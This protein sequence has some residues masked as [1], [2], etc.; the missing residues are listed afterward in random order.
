MSISS[1]IA[2]ILIFAGAVV[3]AYS[4]RRFAELPK[5]L[6]HSALLSE[7]PRLKRFLSLHQWLMIFFLYG[8]LV[9][10][11]SI[12][13][14]IHIVNELFVSTIFF[15]GALFVLFGIMLEKRM[16][17]SLEQRYSEAVTAN[18]SLQLKQE[19]LISLNRQLVSEMK[20][21]KQAEE[22][23]RKIQDELHQSQKMQA[24]GTLAGG[25]AHD[26]NNILTGIIGFADLIKMKLAGS[27]S[28]MEKYV[29]TIIDSSYQASGLTSKL[30]AFA[31]KGR[32]EM[33][34]VN[35]HGIIGDVIKLLK[36]SIDKR[37]RITADLSAEPPTVLGDPTQLQNTVLNLAVNASEAM[38]QG[39]ELNIT[40]KKV[41]MDAEKVKQYNYKIE[42]GN[43]LLLSVSDTGTGMD[44]ITKKR[45][46]EPFFTTKG[47]GEG[48]GLG[49]ASVY[50][51]VKDHHGSIE[52]ES[53]PGKGSIFTICLPLMEQPVISTP[54]HP[55]ELTKGTGRILI[56]D[57]E[58]IIRNMLTRI[59][60]SLGYTVDECK[61]GQEAVEYYSKN[62]RNIDII[63]L[64][65]MMPRLGGYDCFLQLKEINPDV[66]AIVA[67][68]YSAGKDARKIIEKGALCFIEKPFDVRKVSQ[69]VHEVLNKK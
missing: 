37:I 11:F 2:S 55:A 36:H 63:I 39:G 58:E 27:D 68:G 46:F 15:F 59:F 22:K 42:P 19:E 62:F 41:Q 66:K 50:G 23:Q 49:L 34:T 4:I 65:V 64:D 7:R 5:L 21:R 35:I 10:L 32:Y 28:D 52:V 67:S 51:I 1:I 18:E 44:D 43:Y 54:E 20:R 29:N 56:V 33:V 53:E 69:V 13:A 48:V 9:V 25:I 3:M 45:L 38:P 12:I 8:Y 61:D 31:R 30:L 40:T 6:K 16:L 47:V 26:F 60:E 14:K 24:I 57:D 17:D